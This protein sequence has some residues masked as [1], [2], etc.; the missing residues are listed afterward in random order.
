MYIIKCCGYAA[1]PA[2]MS[3]NN[4]TAYVAWLW[5]KTVPPYFS[6]AR[7]HIH[8]AIWRQAHMLNGCINGKQWNGE[9]GWEPGTRNRLSYR[10]DMLSRA[11][12][13]SSKQDNTNHR[14]H[15]H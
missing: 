14:E 7:G 15:E 11:D 10:R 9:T 5:S 6:R 13:G 8:G 12:G 2:G 1:F 3:V 4:R